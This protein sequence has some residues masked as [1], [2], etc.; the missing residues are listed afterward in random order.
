MTI[1]ASVSEVHV[2]VGGAI[3]ALL[4]A[5]AVVG[6]R[7]ASRSMKARV[8]ALKAMDGRLVKLGIGHSGAGAWSTGTL[9]LQ[10]S[11]FGS[12]MV[13]L[14]D[15]SGRSRN[16]PIGDVKFVIDPESGESLFQSVNAVQYF[17]PMDSAAGRATIVKRSSAAAPASFFDPRPRDI[18]RS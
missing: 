3:V 13:I 6:Q 9:T 2:L 17:A 10:L 14:T 16:V 1:Q 4:G 11:G 12:I 7:L 15:Q 8:A 18:D 5:I